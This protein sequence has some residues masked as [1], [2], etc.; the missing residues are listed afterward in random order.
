MAEGGRR[1]RILSRCAL[2]PEEV[3]LGGGNVKNLQELPSG[4]REGDNASAFLGGF[5]LWEKDGGLRSSHRAK[6]C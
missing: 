2:E 4:C 3:V 5:R 1:S 6:V